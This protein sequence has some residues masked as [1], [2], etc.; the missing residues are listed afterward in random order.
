M[1]RSPPAASASRTAQRCKYAIA[2]RMPRATEARHAEKRKLS[3]GNTSFTP[4][5]F[6][7]GGACRGMRR[8]LTRTIRWA[9]RVSSTKPAATTAVRQMG[10]YRRI[11]GSGAA[12]LVGG[13]VPVDL[14]ARDE[15]V[16]VALRFRA[17]HGGTVVAAR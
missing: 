6:R 2:R 17:A 9:A 15:E 16:A 11:T 8:S 14:V 5:S 12:A 1:T 4:P 10:P 3:G 7:L 13:G